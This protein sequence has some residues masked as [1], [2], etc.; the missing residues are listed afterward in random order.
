MTRR[1]HDVPTDRPGKAVKRLTLLQ[2]A[3]IAVLSIAGIAALYAGR[4]LLVPLALAVMICLL[5]NAMATAIARTRLLGRGLRDGTATVVAVVA[6]FG[7]A[8]VVGQ[9]LVNNLP[10]IGDDLDPENSPIVASLLTLGAWIG[11]PDGA[12]LDWLLGLYPFETLLGAGISFVRD[13]VSNASFVVLYVLFLLIDQRYFD[14]KL[15]ALVPDPE[16]QMRVS[17]TLTDLA[18]EAQVYLWLMFLLSL[19]VGLTTFAI[20]ALFGLKGAAFW[21]FV[22]FIL[23]FVPTIGSIMA[24][25]VP[26]TYALLTFDDPATLGALLLL[27]GATQFVA[28]EIVMPRLM[29]NSLNLSTVVV[30]F[31]LL[32]WGALWGPV[33]MFLGIPITVILMGLCARFD[34]ARPIAI[35]LSKDGTLPER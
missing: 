12:G 20:C 24:V 11:M 14:A 22:A 15:R 25:V 28:G 32:F 33:G 8:V 9:I 10:P 30:L 35:V 29:G 5:V 21:G 23:N 17:E 34:R 13:L 27:L 18:R 26:A 7:A 31:A 4:A 3:C 6:F 1:S 2:L 19:G 16:R